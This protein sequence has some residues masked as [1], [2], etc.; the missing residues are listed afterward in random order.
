MALTEVDQESYAELRYLCKNLLSKVSLL[1]KEK[2]VSVI[3][4]L[5]DI[6]RRFMIENKTCEFSPPTNFRK[7]IYEDLI[8][9][10]STSDIRAVRSGL[11]LN[12]TVKLMVIFLLRILHHY[13]P[14]PLLSYQVKDSKLMKTDT[15][16]LN[17]LLLQ[18]SLDSALKENILNSL[19]YIDLQGSG[20]K[21]CFLFLPSTLQFF[22]SAA[23]ASEISQYLCQTLVL[24]NHSSAKHRFSSVGSSQ[25]SNFVSVFFYLLHIRYDINFL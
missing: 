7:K 4:D 17:G 8:E 14:Y 18:K 9:L 23:D 10:C 6:V 16:Y 11:S 5:R 12:V 15:Y 3:E 21:G 25:Q 1:K 13:E 24:K 19:K 20:V 22:W 2:K